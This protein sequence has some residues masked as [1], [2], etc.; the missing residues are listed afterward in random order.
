[1]D[2]A[3]K[4]SGKNDISAEIAAL[5]AFSAMRN[6]DKIGALLFSDTVKD[7]IRPGKGLAHSLH[8]IRDIIASDY[9]GN[10]TDINQ[11]L[12]YL[13]RIQKKR[14]V[15]FLISDFIGSIDFKKLN[16][17]SK[18]H[19]LI[20]IR[21]K[22]ILEEKPP[23]FF[24]GSFLDSE[25]QE[26]VAVSM[27]DNLE[28]VSKDEQLEKLFN[29]EIKKRGIDIVNIYTDSDYIKEMRLFFKNRI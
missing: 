25:S 5:V 26:A 16:I 23:E 29:K 14:C 7:Y 20:G 21:I 10:N 22:D 17:I 18:K 15:V 8:I 2:F 11:A 12:D 24:Y 13:M 6:K 27:G 19:D 1:M 4:H 9:K 28:Y 3:S